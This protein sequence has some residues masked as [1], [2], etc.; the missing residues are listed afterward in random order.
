MQHA[1]M[2]TWVFHKSYCLQNSRVH[3]TP[4]NLLTSFLFGKLLTPSLVVVAMVVIKVVL[5]M[6]VVIVVV[7]VLYNRG[8]LRERP[9]AIVA[10][11]A[12]GLLL[13]MGVY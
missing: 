7:V 10:A 13:A 8:P 5:V 4:P 6:V 2:N 12:N 1:V 11:A 3:T 9:F